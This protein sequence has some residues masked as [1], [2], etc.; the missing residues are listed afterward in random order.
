MSRPERGRFSFVVLRKLIIAVAAVLMLV[1]GVG[2]YL[3]REATALPDWYTEAGPAALDEYA[4]EDVADAPP[5][6]WVPAIEQGDTPVEPSTVA[7]PAVAQ[8]AP[9]KSASPERTRKRRNTARHELR[10]FHR[11][12]TKSDG[13]S[14]VK[15]SRAIYED[16]RFQAGVVVDLSRIPKDKLV[17]RDR[18]LYDRAV[19]QFPGITKRDVYI[20]IEDRPVSAD[21]VLQL[22]PAPE[23]RVGNLRYPLDTA[24]RKIGMSPAE[25]RRELDLELHRLGFVDPTHPG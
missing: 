1:I 7:D 6:V 3:W 2:A 13:R 25:L 21:G 24:A 20:G 10:G 9:S 11:R 4:A 8:E 12:G 14:A 19:D 22:G 15:V 18:E 5:P 16:G 17:A 23:V